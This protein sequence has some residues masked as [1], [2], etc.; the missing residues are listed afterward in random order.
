M[1]ESPYVRSLPYSLPAIVGFALVM[2]VTGP[3]GTYEH[4]GLVVRVL[5]FTSSPS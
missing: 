5:Y 3:F 4:M 1:R 2:G